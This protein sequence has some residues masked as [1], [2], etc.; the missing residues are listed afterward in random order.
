[1]FT[2]PQNI[3]TISMSRTIQL[4]NDILAIVSRETDVAAH[5]IL[6]KCRAAEVVDA[7]HITAKVLHLN[8]IYKQRIAQ[9]LGLTERNVSYIIAMFDGR[10][11]YD[12]VLR[13]NYERVLKQLGN[14]EE[15]S[16]L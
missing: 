7:R 14:I 2:R 11:A 10:V 3:N 16:A 8:G 1:M 6:S 15:T 12:R 9:V 4:A 13:N 5:Q